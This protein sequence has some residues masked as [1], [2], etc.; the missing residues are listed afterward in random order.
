[1]VHRISIRNMAQTIVDL[2]RSTSC[3]RGAPP[4]WDEWAL[5]SEL[6][7][8]V[9]LEINRMPNVEIRISCKV[10]GLEPYHQC[11]GCAGSMCHKH[12]NLVCSMINGSF[13]KSLVCHH[14]ARSYGALSPKP[15]PP[16]PHTPLLELQGDPRGQ[17]WGSLQE[18]EREMNRDV[19]HVDGITTERGW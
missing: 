11:L 1:M 17:S 7:P 5:Y 15:P 9:R 13:R 14:C 12:A 2:R 16:S 10:C 19:S 3:L 4:H 6:L 18:Q 8:H